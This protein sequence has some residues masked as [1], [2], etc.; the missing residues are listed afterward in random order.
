MVGENAKKISVKSATVELK[1]RFTHSNSIQPK[2]TVRSRKGKRDQKIIRSASL[3]D[4]YKNTAP[5]AHWPLMS[6]CQYG[7]S[8]GKYGF[9]KNL[10]KIPAMLFKSGGCSGFRR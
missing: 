7:V 4:S 9:K 8:I 3:P 5:W 1:R 10:V 6:F 2:I